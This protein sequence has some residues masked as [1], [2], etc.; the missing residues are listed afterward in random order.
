MHVPTADRKTSIQA[1]QRIRTCRCGALQRT[2]NRQEN[3]HT[4]TSS[5][6][7]TG[8][9][10]FSEP[11]VKGV[12]PNRDTRT[13]REIFWPSE[14]GRT[15]GETQI[16]VLARFPEK[17]YRPPSRDPYSRSPAAGYGRLT[18]PATPPQAAANLRRDSTSMHRSSVGRRESIS[19]ASQLP[20]ASN[21][22]AKNGGK[23]LTRNNSSKDVSVR[24]SSGRADSAR[25]DEHSAANS[26][27]SSSRLSNC[28]TPG[29]SAPNSARTDGR[30]THR[31]RYYGESDDRSDSARTRSSR[32][33][34]PD[35]ARRGDYSAREGSYSERR[36]DYSAREGSYSE[37]RGDYSAREGN[38]S[39][40]QGGQSSRRMSPDS[41]R[42]DNYSARSN[43]SGVA[44][45]NSNAPNSS[46]SNA[47]NGSRLSS[48]M[49]SRDSTPRS[50][51]G[52]A[53]SRASNP[54]S[55]RK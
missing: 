40:R 29:S 51:V 13:G 41:A 46:R 2:P 36:G 19:E 34:T 24:S 10:P 35:S 54:S 49:N 5:H 6:A 12:P 55:A 25:R 23:T 14:S 53:S 22:T 26:R 43:V 42:R 3:K 20:R 4:N 39:A 32:S 50:S 17:L 1:H 48:Q 30:G 9:E 52:R 21:T 31:D 18:L 28:G 45:A 33:S 8:V 7:H 47:P 37:R 44:R 11:L 38:D 15:Y 27:Q 16:N